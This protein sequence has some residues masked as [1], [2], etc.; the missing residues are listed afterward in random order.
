MRASMDSGGH[1]SPGEPGNRRGKLMSM[2][3]VYLY[4]EKQTEHATLR[5]YKFQGI[6]SVTF[7]QNIF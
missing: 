6:F 2:S 5:H 4:H 1:L 7:S 3:L